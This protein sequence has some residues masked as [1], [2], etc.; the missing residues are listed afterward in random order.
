MPRQAEDRCTAAADSDIPRSACPARRRGRLPPSIVSRGVTHAILQIEHVT[1]R[2]VSPCLLRPGLCPLLAP[3]C[4]S[5]AARSLQRPA[6]SSLC[7][8][9]CASGSETAAGATSS[10]T[11]CAARPAPP[12][13]LRL[14]GRCAPSAAPLTSTAQCRRLVRQRGFENLSVDQLVEELTARGLASVPAAIRASTTASIKAALS[15][16]PEPTK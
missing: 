13:E 3:A 8:S 5:T 7:C 10:E 2:S 14:L 11:R 9:S 12:C 15:P 16:P 1:A 6:S 4:L